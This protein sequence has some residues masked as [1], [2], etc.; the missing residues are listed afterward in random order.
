MWDMYSTEFSRGEYFYRNFY[1]EKSRGI[2]VHNY[3]IKKSN[4]KVS[5]Q[6]SAKN[7]YTGFYIKIYVKQKDTRNLQR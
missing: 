6:K 2:R 7:K 4:T 5:R 1:R 3:Y